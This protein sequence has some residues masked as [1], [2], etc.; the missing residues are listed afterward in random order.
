MRAPSPEP[1][2]SKNGAFRDGTPGPQLKQSLCRV[3]VQD[4]MIRG[5]TEY[6][7]A[8]LKAVL[9]FCDNIDS[10]AKQRGVLLLDYDY[11]KRKYD[12]VVVSARVVASELGHAWLCAPVEGWVARRSGGRS[13]GVEGRGSDAGPRHPVGMDACGCVS[14]ASRRFWPTT[15]RARDGGLGRGGMFSATEPGL[16][17]S[18]TGVDPCAVPRLV[19]LVEA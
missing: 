11:H 13:R 18:L 10:L 12:S 15:G 14:C 19:L 4:A 1:R 9:E 3:A 5:L 17:V 16:R 7:E 8:P 6:L 2:F